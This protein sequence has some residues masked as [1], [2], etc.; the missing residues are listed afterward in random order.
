M[1]VIHINYLLYSF[2]AKLIFKQ[3]PSL[4]IYVYLY[5]PLCIPLK[6]LVVVCKV[7]RMYKVFV[8]AKPCLF[9]QTTLFL[10]KYKM[11]V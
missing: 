8:T 10:K 7:K 11:E 1:L 2:L 5:T 3:T 4:Q 9:L 6:L